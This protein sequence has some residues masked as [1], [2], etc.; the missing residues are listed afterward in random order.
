MPVHC[1]VAICKSPK[2]ASYYR[3]PSDPKLCKSWVMACRR[4]KSINTKFARICDKHFL[5]SDFIRDL[6]NELLQRPLEKA[7]R[8]GAVPTINLRPQKICLNSVSKKSH[9][10]ERREQK[11]IVHDLLTTGTQ[12]LWLAIGKAV[13]VNRKFIS[14]LGITPF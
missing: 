8:A 4:S 12:I 7:L 14:W 10:A 2:D 13:W 3:F 6:R 1:S 9:R 5:P 11:R